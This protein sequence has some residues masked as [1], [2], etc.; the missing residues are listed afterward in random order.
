MT[1]DFL[2]PLI[3]I[4]LAEDMGAGDITS[5]LLIPAGEQAEMAFVA[6]EPMVVCGIDVPQLVYAELDKK[7]LVSVHMK[8]GAV[9]SAGSIIATVKG[10]AQAILTGER[11]ALNI[12]SRMCGIATVTRKYVEE[13]A[14]TKAKIL[15]TRKTMPGMRSLDKYAV[16]IGGGMNHRM[17]LDDMILIKDNH[18]ATI[19]SVNA[20]VEKAKGQGAP[21]VV[22]CDTLE[23]CKEALAAKPD[24]IMLDNMS[25]DMLREAVKLAAGEVP[26]EA[27]GGVNLS[28]VK[29]V[30]ETGVDYIS[31]GAL[32]HSVPAVDIGLDSI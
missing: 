14:G 6:R 30:A 5:K 9:V 2:L 17:R 31:I 26:L 8:E 28:N 1:Q 20:A 19:G 11:V 7:V 18:I 10:P 4:S 25:L 3:K 13:V 24:R 32:T 29:Q 27:T 12:M 15:D 21:V 22:E 23:Q 16:R